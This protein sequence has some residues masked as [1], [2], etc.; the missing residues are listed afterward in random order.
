MRFIITIENTDVQTVPI[1][2][3]YPVSAWIYKIFSRADKH[4]TEW[5]H[6][7]GYKFT[8]TGKFNLFTFSG[9]QFQGAN[10]KNEPSPSLVVP[11]GKH[12]FQVS[13]VL[14]E[15]ATVFISALFMN[16]ELYINSK[17]FRSTFLVTSVKHKP[18]PRFEKV[19]AFSALSP[20]V[21]SQPREDASGKTVAQYLSPD[22]EE[23]SKLLH[24]NTLLRY[25]ESPAGKTTDQEGRAKPF[26]RYSEL[27]FDPDYWKLTIHG[28]PKAKLQTIKAGT[29]NQ[30]RI[31]GYLFDFELSAPPALLEFIY[32]AG[33]G[34][35]GSLGF[36][37][38][39]K[40]N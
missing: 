10:F 35:K 18:K 14:E 11:A 25:L 32:D 12:Q 26:V 17:E 40:I 9:I 28:T 2:Y 13:F 1:N 31:K 8:G 29:P 24:E 5:L 20:V 30:T 19:S 21:L 16:Q 39:E 4:F 22:K 23:Y 15:E 33:I 38:T 27:P 6:D 37:F 36:G 3:Q 7:R 34:E